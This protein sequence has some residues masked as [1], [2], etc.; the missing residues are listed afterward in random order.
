MKNDTVR[1]VADERLS[2]G[3]NLTVTLP[4]TLQL[5]N[6]H[7]AELTGTQCTDQ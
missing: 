7:H 6:R 4:C 5:T 2:R 1:K 3:D